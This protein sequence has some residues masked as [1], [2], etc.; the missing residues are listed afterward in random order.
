MKTMAKPSLLFALAATILSLANAAVKPHKTHSLLQAAPPPRV[1]RYH[2]HQ[3]PPPHSKKNHRRPEA[4]AHPPAA[5]PPTI[6]GE[7]GALPPEPY[8]GFYEFT[9]RCL[10]KL[11][12]E[13]GLEIFQ[14]IFWEDEVA[15]ISR[16][17]C[18]KLVAVGRSCHEG[19]LKATMKLPGLP[20]REKSVVKRRDAQLWSNCISIIGVPHKSGGS[21]SPSP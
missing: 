8:Q 14:G 2:P 6:S 3:A 7:R 1:F 9:D 19:L 21:P 16:K 12:E 10:D 4:H 18:Q 17:C 11:T 5:P 20:K 13:C 15:E